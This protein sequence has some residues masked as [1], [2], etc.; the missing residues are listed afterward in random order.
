MTST[1]MQLRQPF[2]MV[3]KLNVIHSVFQAHQISSVF[4][5]DLVPFCLFPFISQ[6]PRVTSDQAF[7]AWLLYFIESSIFSSP[8]RM[9]DCRCY[10]YTVSCRA[11][12]FDMV[13]CSREG[14]VSMEVNHRPNPTGWPRWGCFAVV[15]LFQLISLHCCV[16]LAHLHKYSKTILTLIQYFIG[17]LYDNI[18]SHLITAQSLSK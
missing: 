5:L 14:N 18:L 2:K 17:L 13:T 6:I 4:L 12:Q 15:E 1:R 16:L 8:W 3:S 7:L 10:A 11:T 9:L